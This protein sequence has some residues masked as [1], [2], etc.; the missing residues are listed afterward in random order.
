M[1]RVQLRLQVL[2]LLYQNTH[3]LHERAL[4]AHLVVL[5]EALVAETRLLQQLWL[6]GLQCVTEGGVVRCEDGVKILCP[7]LVGGGGEEE[8]RDVFGG[9]GN[10]GILPVQHHALQHLLLL[11]EQ[12]VLLPELA[13][14]DGVEGGGDL[15]PHAT[16]HL[17]DSSLTLE[18][19]QMNN[20]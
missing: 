11:P 10:L 12:D 9:G 2:H 18:Y 3:R 17:R 13:V 4:G 15:S 7:Q 14:D 6:Q 8:E 16:E 20:Y 1:T 19:D 5:V